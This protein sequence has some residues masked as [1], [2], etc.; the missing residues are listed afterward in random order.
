MDKNITVLRKFFTY[1]SCERNITMV[2]LRLALDGIDY[3]TLVPMLLPMV[4]KNPIAAKAA[5]TAYKIKT[6]NMSQSERDALAVKLL[7]DNK[8]KILTALNE[9]VAD[10]GVKGYVIGFDAD[11]L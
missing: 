1:D 10:K 6:A 11:V 4:I 7:T 8:N 3:D 9:K 5:M 2:E